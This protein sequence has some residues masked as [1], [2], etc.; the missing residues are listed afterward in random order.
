MA[1]SVFMF[2]YCLVHTVEPYFFAVY[3]FF[4]QNYEN[5]NSETREMREIPRE[6]KVLQ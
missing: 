6:K 4:S 5:G 3:L 1:G 2:A